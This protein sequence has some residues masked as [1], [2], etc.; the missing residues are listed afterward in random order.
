MSTSARGPAYPPP[1][2][3][4]K[5][6][7]GRHR[8]LAPK[9]GARVSPLCLG[10]ANFGN[11]WKHFMGECTKETAWEM[12][13]YFY[14][15]GGNFVDTAGNYQDEESEQWLGEWMEER[16]RRDEMFVATKYCTPWQVHDGTQH[17][18]Q[19]NFGGAATKNLHLSVEASLKKLRTTYVDLLY[20][21]YW[22][23]TTSPEEL[24]QSLNALVLAGKT[25]YL[26]ISDTPAWFVV[27]CNAYAAH[28]GLR[29][30][31]VYQGKW[32]AADRDF[33]RDIIPMCQDQ[34]MA[35]APWGVLGSGA[36]KPQ[37][38]QSDR[39]MKKEEEEEE[40]QGR[41]MPS[42]ISKNA[43]AA[44]VVLEKIAARMDTAMTSVALA[45][46]M[47]KALYVFPIVGGRKVE[48]LKG[49]IEALGLKLT[50]ED[51]AEIESAYE[52]D[53]GFPGDMLGASGWEPER[54]PLNR[55]VGQI[56]YVGAGRRIEPK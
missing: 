8:I 4:M 12:L 11:A 47:H 3:E 19:T 43:A 17:K 28:H 35:L 25:L 56:D 14:E 10:A 6:R 38:K 23:M 9:A 42:L 27:K 33:E 24:M 2:P 55:Q 29:P 51:M 50:E 54:N 31:S 13:D 20:V 37:R 30:F 32:S 52:F 36:F 45:Y 26:G 40:E 15:M 53:L 7:L 39:E 5:S 21:H 48:H 49:N 16:G 22:D 18:I 44:S 41:N 1:A 46:V 34:G